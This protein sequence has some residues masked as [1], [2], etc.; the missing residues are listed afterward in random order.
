MSANTGRANLNQ[1]GRKNTK[2]DLQSV[3]EKKETTM[4]CLK[5]NMLPAGMMLGVFA[6]AACAQ[7]PPSGTS[8][9]VPVTQTIAAVN[10]DTGTA[11]GVGAGTGTGT[12][13]GTGSGTGAGGVGA[14]VGGDVG[15]VAGADAGVSAGTGGVSAGVGADVGGVGIGADVGI[16]GGGGG[17][18]SNGGSQR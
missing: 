12:G 16:G 13:T 15:D 8:T 10:P 7:Q 4:T 11:P 17:G 9:M 3:D 2:N 5:F 1:L 18:G 6:L 14:G